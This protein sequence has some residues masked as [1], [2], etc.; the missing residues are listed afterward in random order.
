MASE[1]VQ[2]TIRTVI[3]NVQNA[4]NISDD[5]IV[6]GKS[7]QEHDQALDAVMQALQ[8]NGLTVNKDKCEFNKTKITSF[9]VVFSK[10]GI[11]PDPKKVQSVKD[12]APLTNISELRSFLGRTNYS[13]RFV[14]NYASICEPIHYVD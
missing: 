13:S 10:D 1:I 12:A 9:G 8:R 3:Q 14:K 11:S 6:Y 7:Q 5:I 2:E 4:K